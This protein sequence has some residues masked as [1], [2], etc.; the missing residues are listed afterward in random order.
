MTYFARITAIV[1]SLYPSAPKE[2]DTFTCLPCSS[3][4]CTRMLPHIENLY[5]FRGLL[6]Y[7][8][9]GPPKRG[10]SIFPASQVSVSA[11]LFALIVG[12]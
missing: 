1:L 3:L 12:S 5:T 4:Q 11:R 10:N 6:Q 2:R 9:S 7:K 8:I